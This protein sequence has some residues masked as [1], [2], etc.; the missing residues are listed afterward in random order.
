[1]NKKGFTMVELLAVMAIMALILVILIPNVTEPA[2]KT[3]ETINTA[4]IETVKA[5]VLKE[6]EKTINSKAVCTGKI[7]S[8]KSACIYDAKEY[9]QKIDSKDTSLTGKIYICY[10]N[11]KLDITAI[12]SNEPSYTCS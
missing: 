11:N 8:T 3:K 10:D 1:M 4:K 5:E 6:A 2:N 7:D 12:Y 9:L